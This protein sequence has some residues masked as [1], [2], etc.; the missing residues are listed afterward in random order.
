MKKNRI[1]ETDII[2]AVV[3]DI[4]GHPMVAVMDTGFKTIAQVI[5]YAEC[6]CEICK[7]HY[8][9][10]ICITNITNEWSSC[11]NLFGRKID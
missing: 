6:K 10:Y 1:S 9:D 2:K 3:V 5:R 4:K 7:A 8:V 11:Y